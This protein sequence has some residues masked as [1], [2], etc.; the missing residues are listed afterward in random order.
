MALP[1]TRTLADFRAE[2]G[3]D[4]DDG[5]RGFIVENADTIN[6]GP[7]WFHFY[8]TGND[9]HVWK[10]VRVRSSPSSSQKPTLTWKQLPP[11]GEVFVKV[12]NGWSGRVVQ[13]TEANWEKVR[14]NVGT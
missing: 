5:G 1:F 6:S 14:Q 7:Q 13:G 9:S 2:S 3:G 4:R 10:S 12:C 11:G 8:R